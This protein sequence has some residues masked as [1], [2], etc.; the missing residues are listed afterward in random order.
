MQ[1]WPIPISTNYEV[2][3]AG[4]NPT[5]SPFASF[6]FAYGYF[7]F[8]SPYRIPHGGSLP[9]LFNFT[10]DELKLAQKLKIL[11]KIVPKHL[12]HKFNIVPKQGM[13]ESLHGRLAQVSREQQRGAQYT[14]NSRPD[15][16][17]MEQD[18][19]PA[20]QGFSDEEN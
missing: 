18:T 1:R 11:H 8:F 5:L 14:H 10:D 9:E 20:P 16:R 17:Y 4:N 19:G 3:I 13:D 15:E 7:V 6:C 12:R 2:S